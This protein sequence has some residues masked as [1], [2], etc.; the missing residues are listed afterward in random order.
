MSD[1]LV[2]GSMI[3]FQS[4]SFSSTHKALITHL[5][6]QDLKLFAILVKVLVQLQYESTQIFICQ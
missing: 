1:Y 3:I 4:G 5:H 6:A 2:I